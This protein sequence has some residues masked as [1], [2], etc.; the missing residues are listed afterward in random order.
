MVDAGEGVQ[1]RQIAALNEKQ[2]M[3]ILTLMR[4]KRLKWDLGQA[5]YNL[6][7]QTPPERLPYNM[8]SDKTHEQLIAEQAEVQ[9]LLDA[10]FAPKPKR[11]PKPVPAVEKV[12]FVNPGADPISSSPATTPSHPVS[13]GMK[14]VLVD[15]EPDTA[16]SCGNSGWP[17][18]PIQ[19]ELT[20]LHTPLPTLGV[21]AADGIVTLVDG[22]PV[23]TTLAIAE[24]TEL[25]HA[26]V[27]K[28]VRTYQA[29]LEEFGRV[30]F[31]IRPFV[32]A[33]GLQ[34][35]EFATLN[36]PQ[37]TLILTYMR[38]SDIVRGFKKRL[39]KAF[40]MLAKG[41]QAQF[42]I[43]QTMHEA[44]RLAAD[45]SEK[46]AVM[47]ERL[48]IAAPKADA[49][50]LISGADGMFS[51]RDSAKMLKQ[52]PIA[53]NEWLRTEMRWMSKNARGIYKLLMLPMMT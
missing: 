53:F 40:F 3:L 6:N 42:A 26:S 52:H 31:E 25:D 2:A 27:I 13:A 39:V 49:L 11:K 38:N 1:L 16:Q 8:F 48:A 30:G 28:L 23:T 34:Q 17:A 37:S 24:G 36:E 4:K 12:D 45:L 33:G 21:S 32:A 46:N 9:V 15:D 19:A 20:T 14:F 51:L 7:Q 29:D 47:T 5:F 35:R 43:P 44:L 18:E 22:Q 41:V 50:D 10:V